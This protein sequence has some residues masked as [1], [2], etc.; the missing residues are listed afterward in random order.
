MGELNKLQW[1]CRRGTL[2]LDI[3]L[4]RYLDSGYPAADDPEKNTFIRLLNLEDSE[5]L[6]YLMGEQTPDSPPL[7]LLVDK[8][9]HLSAAKI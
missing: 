6:P 3:M 5:L 4:R 9:R 7:A 2:E 8:I 1:R